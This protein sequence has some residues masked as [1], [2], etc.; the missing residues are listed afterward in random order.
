M[1]KFD[2]IKYEMGYKERGTYID[3]IVAVGVFLK[4]V[5]DIFRLQLETPLT[6]VA[7]RTPMFYAI[8]ISVVATIVLHI[9]YSILSGSNDTQEDQRD[10][11]ISRFGDW[12]GLFPLSSGAMLG[13]LLAMF[14]QP[15]FWIAN[16]IFAGFFVSSI[17][18]S[19]TRLVGYRRGFGFA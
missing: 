18:S 8:L 5:W 10:R 16:A 1:S 9:V 17:V 3:L 12:V 13:L 2:Y 4:Y 7:F 14:D 15:H 19:I 6:E 11:Q